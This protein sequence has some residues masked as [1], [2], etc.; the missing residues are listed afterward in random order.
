ML[1]FRGVFDVFQ[2]QL[3][4]FLCQFLGPTDWMNHS[5]HPASGGPLFLVIFF[6]P[7]GATLC[8]F[9]RDDFFWGSMM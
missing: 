3:K 2:Q 5:D 6:H 8:F 1:I 4:V 7:P 9:G